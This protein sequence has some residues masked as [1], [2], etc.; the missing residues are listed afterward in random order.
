MFGFSGASNYERLKPLLSR[1][2]VVIADA[3]P[4]VGRVVK[5]VLRHTGF[6]NVTLVGDGETALQ[7]IN[8]RDVDLLI[9]DWRMKPVNGIKLVHYLRNA[10]ESP[11]PY[12]PIIMLT[13]KA[14]MKDV[15]QARD[16]GVT[17]FLVKPFS[18]QRLFERLV[19]VIENPRSFILSDRYCGP[20]RRRRSDIPP[21]GTERRSATPQPE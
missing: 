18:A 19:M 10:K 21:S 6:Q 13:G 17:E 8:K 12:L 11:N 7:L 9:T 3:D 15:A 5:D 20:D 14:E 16:N 1:V 4:Q 2:E